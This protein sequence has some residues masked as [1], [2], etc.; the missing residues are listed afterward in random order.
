M[1]KKSAFA[2]FK[3]YYLSKWRLYQKKVQADRKSVV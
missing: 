3:K 1:Q 2:K